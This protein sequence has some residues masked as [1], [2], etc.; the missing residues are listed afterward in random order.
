MSS[1]SKRTKRSRGRTNEP[2]EKLQTE[3]E[4]ESGSADSSMR[5]DGRARAR[6][7]ANCF[8]DGATQRPGQDNE[9]KIESQLNAGEK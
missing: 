9:R 5:D 6:S 2:N 3:G 7:G 8:A 4:P 1:E